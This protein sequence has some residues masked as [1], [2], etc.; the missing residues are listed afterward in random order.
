LAKSRS[1]LLAGT[2][3]AGL[4][5]AF[6]A[7]IGA[8]ADAAQQ[9]AHAGTASAVLTAAGSTPSCSAVRKNLRAYAQRYGQQGLHEIGCVQTSA[10]TAT[11]KTE[12][13]LNSLPKQKAGPAAQAFCSLLPGGTW[14]LT[15]TAACLKSALIYTVVNLNTG[16]IT[17]NADFT[18]TQEI[19]AS[20]TS[21]NWSE[22]DTLT[23]DTEEGTAVGLSV[24]WTTACS[25][26]CSPASASPWSGSQPIA[27]GE[28]L[29]GTTD[30][31]DNTLTRAAPGPDFMHHT[32][33]VDVS[34]PDVI[35][36]PP[37]STESPNV[38]CD[39]VL[40]IAKPGCVFPDATPEYVVPISQY[41]AAAAFIQWA[42]THLSGH[43]GNPAL[44][45]APLTRLGNPKQ[46]KD[47]RRII[48]GRGFRALAAVASDSCDEFPFASSKQSGALNGV[49]TGRDCAQV[50][51]VRNPAVP[52]TAPLAQRWPSV[53]VIGTFTGNEACARG[54]IPL[55]LN[56][57]VGR[58]GLATL[59]REERILPGDTYTVVVTP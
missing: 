41:G 4:A 19:D 30:F 24:S 27:E 22:T 23:L 18:A 43:W 15:R 35:P 33:T 21:T 29:S 46:A 47:N 9:P 39:A 34:Q 32:Y 17:G 42:Q 51:A 2:I 58:D 59:T 12:R 5:I 54:H 25:S 36:A 10:V 31:A 28:T 13:T 20:A 38:R 3:T 53:K 37:A 45:G 26:P 6:A 11:P 16:V 57:E 56:Q 55:M 8:P 50:E 52:R 7:G 1:R 40:R 48:C 44:G 14:V 49:T